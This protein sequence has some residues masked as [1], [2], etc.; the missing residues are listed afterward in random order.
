MGWMRNLAA[1]VVA[2]V[3]LAAPSGAAAAEPRL[4]DLLQSIPR[5]LV[6][7]PGPQ[8]GYLLGFTSSVQNVGDGP[9]H[10]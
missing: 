2:L 4:P 9:L 8:G 5:N 7:Q 3:A 1:I 10:L 6:V